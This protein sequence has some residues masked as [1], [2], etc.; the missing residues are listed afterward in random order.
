MAEDRTPQKWDSQN[1]EMLIKVRPPIGG[2]AQGLGKL[3]CLFVCLVYSPTDISR[4][5]VVRG[6]I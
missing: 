3:V 6:R 2:R 5:D 1:L 4:L